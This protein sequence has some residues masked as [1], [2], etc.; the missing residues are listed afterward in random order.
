MQLYRESV[1]IS[2]IRSFV[3]TLFGFVG[4]LLGLFVLAAFAGVMTS[5][6]YVFPKA[7]LYVMPNAK[8]ELVD[9]SEASAVVLQI[10]I[11]NVIGSAQLNSDK[12][13]TALSQAVSHPLLGKR[14]KAIMLNIDSPGGSATDSYDIYKAI[15]DFKKAKNIPVYSYVSGLCA[16]GGFFIAAAS[17]MIYT[18]PAAIIGS[19]GVISGPFFNFSE[20]MQKIGIAAKTLTMGKDK[21]SYNPFRPW[22]SDEGTDFDAMI[23]L[24]Y[25][26]FAGSVAA[27]RPKLTLDKLKEYGAQIYAAP[28]AEK[29]GYIDNGSSTYC[30]ALSALVTAANI[31]EK[32][33][34]QVIEVHPVPSLLADLFENKVD[35][36]TKLI[37]GK[38]VSEIE[39][40]HSMSDQVLYLY[41]P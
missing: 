31:S 28:D 14:V 3:K 41:Q 17:D 8:G 22:K 23:K 40:K 9:D 12:V 32:E 10:D 18:S 36:L 15:L 7:N 16:S 35:L 20:G 6:P 27:H 13:A 4:F 37:K 26:L 25:D 1:F 11:R 38:F 21:D 33:G 29:L 30:E 34:Y 24:N 2:G 5:S 19:V 39:M